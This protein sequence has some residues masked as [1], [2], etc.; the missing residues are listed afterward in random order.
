M[1]ANL[2]TLGVITSVKSV[3]CEVAPGEPTRRQLRA[4]LF[5]GKA[6]EAVAPVTI[7][8]LK[9]AAI[10]SLLLLLPMLF[11]VT[12]PPAN[13]PLQ[14]SSYGLPTSE[15][16]ATP[17]LGT[18]PPP[19]PDLGA[20][21]WTVNR[22]RNPDFEEWANPHNPSGWDPYARGGAY[23]W[24]AT[25]PP[26]HVSQGSY[27]AGLQCY[28]PTGQ[29]NAAGWSQSISAQLTNL[30]LTFDWYSDANGDPLHDHFYAELLFGDGRSIYYALN[31]SL[32]YSNSSTV[33]VYLLRQ[34]PNQW[35]T[36]ARNVTNDYVSIPLF[37]KSVAYVST[38]VL[39][40]TAEA[41]GNTNQYLRG[42]VDDVNLVNS[43]NSY[44]WIGGTTRDGNFESHGTGTQW[45]RSVNADPSDV[46]QSSTSHSGSWS[47]N[48]TVASWGN[49]SEAWV[50]S[51]PEARLTSLN[52]GSLS[53][54]WRLAVQNLKPSS[55][56][57]LE[58]N[59]DNDTNSFSVFY[60][61]TYGGASPPYANSSGSL[62]ILVDLFNVT[63]TWNHFQR[64]VWQDVAAYF[65]TSEVFV[66]TL[67]FYSRIQPSAGLPT[68]IVV[69]L[70]DVTLGSAAINAAGYEDQGSTASFI[71]GWS[72]IGSDF[73]VT[74]TAYAG[75]KA[76]NLTIEDSRN[77]YLTQ[78]LINRPLNSTR[79]TYLD[80][81][82]RLEDYTPAS[83]ANAYISVTFTNGQYLGY[84]LAVF[85]GELPSNT[86]SSGFFN[87]TG[88][89]TTG[90]WIAMHRDLAHDYEAV[91]GSLPDTVFWQL[92]QTVN[93]PPSNRL[94][95]LT[96]DLYLYDAPVPRITN[97][98][99]NPLTPEPLDPIQ[100]T[101]TITGQDAQFLHYR[102]NNVSWIVVPMYPIG[103]NDYEAWILGRQHND[104]VEYYVTANDTW[105]WTTTALNG[106]AYWSFTVID[107][108][109]PSLG[110]VARTP[111]NPIYTNQVNVSAIAA[112]PGSH[113]LSCVLYYRSN[114]G[115][116]TSVAMSSTGSVDGYYAYIPARPW[117]TNV[118]YYVNATNFAQ[119]S[120]IDDNAG[121]YY[122][123]IVGDT[124]SPVIS[125]IARNPTVVS[126][127]DT[128]VVGCDITDAGSAVGSALLFYRLN[129]GTWTSAAMT[130]TTGNHYQVSLG[131]PQPYGTVVQ[132]YF[133]SSD[134]AGNRRI[135]NNGGSYYS[136]TVADNVNPSVAITAP[137]ADQT[138]SGT[139]TIAVSASDA[140]TNITHV[141]IVIDGTTVSSDTSSPYEYE[142]NTATATNGVHTIIVIAF[143]FAGN[144]A[145]QSITVTVQN[146]T[147][148]TTTTQPPIPGFPWAAILLA[149]VAAVSLSLLRRR[150]KR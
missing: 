97:V 103:A 139:L 99:R 145:N 93:A 48:V 37:P 55:Y 32:P 107:H 31:G 91:F 14:R 109:P 129:G 28:C 118:E 138:V 21:N 69:L 25:Q 112:D 67:Y 47:A 115:A 51:Q 53:F 20:A 116:F 3:N 5:I 43:T 135:D 123:Y 149:S 130:H 122:W 16:V 9:S 136:Y 133:N 76:A 57:L 60:Y 66:H 74:A 108:T 143:D 39:Y 18:I 49:A 101:A 100:V 50:G 117:N 134:N 144:S 11:G 35:N 75:S 125:N 68:R 102:V 59:C 85:P 70:D 114:G 80:V 24:F 65:H 44:V 105:G 110:S 106:G 84:Y 54:W 56:S 73:T 150:R 142:W 148:P 61:L 42:F 121:G 146:V 27:S 15:G 83:L 52:Q 113:I 128:P 41:V 88:V 90:Q 63:G 10:L 127:L 30:S 147:T 124:V 7:V 98:Q 132:Y 34:P 40:F 95:L 23:T 87:V 140:G 58:I 8:R 92:S 38:W 79:E 111:T 1:G 137:N 126:Y 13:S 62:Y 33:G 6:R 26:W 12:A 82:W 22:I 17:Q 2:E 81:M 36:F 141:D 46:R 104:F 72:Q 77:S 86:S 131:T 19:A 96:D 45:N 29:P 71:R 4:W 119:L 64:N 94:S 89:G 78:A 120:T